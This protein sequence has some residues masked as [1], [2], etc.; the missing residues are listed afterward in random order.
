MVDSVVRPVDVLEAFDESLSGKEV[1][2]SADQ[3]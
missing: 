1:A 2:K 3:A